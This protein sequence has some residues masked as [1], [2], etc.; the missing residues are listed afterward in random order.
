MAKIKVVQIVNHGDEY[1]PDYI[2]DKGRVWFQQYVKDQE[3]PKFG[4]PI[5]GHYE[6]RQLSLPEEPEDNQSRTN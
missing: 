6:W 1:S 2:D 3:S 4:G 5:Q